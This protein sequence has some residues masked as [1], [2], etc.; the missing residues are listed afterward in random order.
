MKIKIIAMG[1]ALASVGLLGPGA[2]NSVGRAPP[3]PASEPMIS[4]TGPAPLTGHA[5]LIGH[6]VATTNW[7]GYAARGGA[8]HGVS[9]HWTQPHAHGGGDHWA[10]F[11]VGL[12]GWGSNSIEQTGTAADIVGG[13]PVYFAWYEMAPAYP[14]HLPNP[15][16]PGDSITASVTVKGG[17]H[18]SLK[19]AD[20]TRGWSRTIHKTHSG[21][22][23]SSAEAI[24]EAPVNRITGAV[25]PLTNFGTV[26][27]TSTKVD[28]SPIGAFHPAKLV[29][30][31]HRGQNKDEV[32]SLSGGAN[33]RATWVRK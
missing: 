33:W 22:R 14:V 28:G 32:S 19:I 7:S 6:A 1:A 31:N 24:V 9:A 25:L 18:Y 21:L 23:H 3:A 10:A 15:V 4:Y 13:R 11:W 12:D 29:M 27:F 30:V 5:P 17:T 8:Y 20:R 16:G 26:H 2:H